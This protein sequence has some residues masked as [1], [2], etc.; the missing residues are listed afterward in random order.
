MRIKKCALCKKT[1]YQSSGRNSSE[2]WLCSDC[3]NKVENLEI[4]ASVDSGLNQT[5]NICDK[6]KKRSGDCRFAESQRNKITACSDWVG[7]NTE[8]NKRRWAKY[9]T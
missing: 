2:Y 9:D 1:A 3:R 7:K 6:C 8:H 4:A 5:G